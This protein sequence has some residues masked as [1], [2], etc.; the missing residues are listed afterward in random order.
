[1]IDFQTLQ[2]LSG[3]AAEADSTCPLCSA[4]RKSFN[5]KKKVLR[6]WNKEPGFA[7]YNCT[8]C[9]ASGSAHDKANGYTNGHAHEP[10]DKV[11]N[12]VMA[13]IGKT[14]AP[15]VV[16]KT[17]DYVDADGALLYQKL[18]YA[19]NKF[20]SWRRPDGNG[21]WIKERGDRVVPYRL[22]DLLK[23]P[24]GTIFL[25]E[26]ERT[27]TASRP[28]VIAPPMSGRKTWSRKRVQHILPVVMS[29]S[30]KTVTTP[31]TSAR[32]LPRRRYTARRRQFVL[33]VCPTVPKTLVSGSTSMRATP[34]SL[35]DYVSMRRCGSRRQ[36]CRHREGENRKVIAGALRAQAAPAA[37]QAPASA[38]TTVTVDDFYAYMP[39]H[40][41]I[42]V[43]TRDTW[44]GSSINARIPPIA[45]GGETKI[46]A[47]DWL[48]KFKPVEQ[49]TWIPGEPMVIKDRFFADGGFSDATASRSSIYTVSR[50][51]STVSQQSISW[52]D[53]L[54]RS[55]VKMRPHYEMA[56]ARVQRPFEKI[57]HAIVLGG[58]Q[59]IGKD[60]AL[61]PVKHAIGP[62]NFVEVSPQHMLARFNGFLKSVILRISEA[63]D[64]G[65][66]D[67][68]KFYD[69]SKAYI[70]APPDVLR[71]DE[72]HLHEYSIP[73]VSGV[74]IT[75]NHKTDGIFLPED[76][77]V[78][79]WLGQN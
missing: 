40:N 62:W 28:L 59:G 63:R 23:Y 19:P 34:T 77:A 55:S 17:Y 53:H 27:P 29:S 42:F 78:T 75:T 21:G 58:A 11:A 49:M 5:R 15:Q 67:R 39:M 54:H 1:M 60:T 61:E 69:H 43:P 35:T 64:L 73:N 45:C 26:G 8:H 68:F 30:S 24:D 48:D 46:K 36:N 32:R 9:S 72:K 57:N 66:F 10:E 50:P 12:A 3:G 33:S 47:S 16:S 38:T 22:P 41:Y 51:S 2:D 6:I 7:T 71:V 65:E 25:C 31:A 37:V 20:F 70:A 79:S 14:A 52:V 74:I 56:G 18:R 76:T 13:A 44:P 4:S